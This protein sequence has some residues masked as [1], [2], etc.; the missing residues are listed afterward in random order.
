V[1]PR[2]TSPQPGTSGAAAGK[3]YKFSQHQ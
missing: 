2:R 3:K 1:E